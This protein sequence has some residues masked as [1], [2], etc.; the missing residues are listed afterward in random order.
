MDTPSDGRTK[1]HM[2]GGLHSALAHGAMPIAADHVAAQAA[3][4]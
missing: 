4:H 1:A 3:S 2:D